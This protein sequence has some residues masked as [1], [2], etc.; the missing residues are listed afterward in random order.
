MAMA[1]HH[2]NTLLPSLHCAHQRMP[3]DA[4]IIIALI[5]MISIAHPNVQWHL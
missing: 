1:R 4:L 2:L 3:F 5:I